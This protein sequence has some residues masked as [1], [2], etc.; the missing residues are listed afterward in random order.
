VLDA[1]TRVLDAAAAT[2]EVRLEAPRE[3]REHA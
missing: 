1:L 3:T 2:V